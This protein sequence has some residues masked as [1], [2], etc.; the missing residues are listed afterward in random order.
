MPRT[1]NTVAVALAGLISCQDPLPLYPANA[2]LEIRQACAVTV[3]RCTACHE[4]DRIVDARHT[5]AG[6]RN[7]VKRMRTF[8]GSGISLDD[9]ETI[10]F[11]LDSRA[12][13]P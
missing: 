9:V 12:E 6:W 7:T 4:S 8:P 5:P 13:A 11:C 2:P 10:L 3:Q 1:I